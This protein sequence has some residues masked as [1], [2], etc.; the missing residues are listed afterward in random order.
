MANVPVAPFPLT[1]EVCVIKAW[2]Q[3]LPFVDAGKPMEALG[4]VAVFALTNGP[5]RAA[6]PVLDEDL[7]ARDMVKCHTL[8]NRAATT[9][10]RG[11]SFAS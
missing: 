2:D 9:I 6:T 8:T 5:D 10:G 4:S 11:G 1:R 7:L 3:A